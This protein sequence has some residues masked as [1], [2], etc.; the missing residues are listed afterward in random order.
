MVGCSNMGQ[1]IN[2]PNA[3]PVCIAMGGVNARIDDFQAL[4]PATASAQ[5]F[6]TAAIQLNAAY[7]TLDAQIRVLADAQA[8]QLQ[9][10]MRNLQNAAQALPAGTTPQ[11]A[12]AQLADEIA[13]VDSAMESARAQLNCPPFPTPQPQ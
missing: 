5:D 10:A 3:M 8:T 11:D 2:T 13:A 12:K 1:P 6:Q 9:G 7:Q 4:D